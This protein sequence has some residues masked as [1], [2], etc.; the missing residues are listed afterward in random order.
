MALYTHNYSAII[1]GGLGGSACC[2]ILS[3]NFGLNCG[4]TVEVV[5]PPPPIFTG[6][7]GGG[8]VSGFFVPLPLKMKQQTRMVLVTVK[9][10]QDNA[11]RRSYVVD[12]SRADMVVKIINLINT[13][14][15]KLSIGINQIK[16]IGRAVTAIFKR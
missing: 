11:W 13:S 12:V 8:P 14:R 3:A 6:G 2:S 1:T 5:I 16:T 15:D 4:C 7:S 10:S 9:F